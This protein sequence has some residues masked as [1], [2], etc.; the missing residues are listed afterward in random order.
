VSSHCASSIASSA[1]PS[2]AI[3]RSALRNAAAI[4]LGSARRLDAR[5]PQRRLADPRLALEDEH[6]VPVPVE[7]V[8]DPRELG[9]PP[10]DG[11]HPRHG[12]TWS[13]WL[14]RPA[15]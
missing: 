8:G 10:E 15:A 6:R 2:R 5:P 3:A 4:V 14:R 9:V 7:E 1:G 11:V 13:R 12:T